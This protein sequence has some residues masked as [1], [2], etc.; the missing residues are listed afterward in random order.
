MV[1]TL[2]LR[3]SV[4]LVALALGAAPLRAQPPATLGP[5]EE[6]PSIP[7]TRVPGTVTPGAEPFP[8]TPNL[9]SGVG[10]TP[11]RGESPLREFGGSISII[12]SAQIAASQQPFLADLFKT[13]PGLDVQQNGGPGR[14]TSIF[15]RGQ[16]SR[17]TKVLVDGIPINDPST[18]QRTFDFGSLN[19]LEIERVEILRGPQSTLY[20]SDAVGG[21]INI[22]TKRGDGPLHGWVSSSAGAYGTTE[23]TTHVAAGNSLF[24]FSMGVSQFDTAG[25]SVANTKYGRF[26]DTEPDGYHQTSLATRFGWT[27]TQNFDIDVVM[28]YLHSKAALD[29]FNQ[30]PFEFVTDDPFTNSRNEQFYGRASARWAILDG[31]FEQRIAFNRTTINRDFNDPNSF[32]P[33]TSTLFHGSTDKVEYQAIA[34]LTENNK[35]TFGIDHTIERFDNPPTQ[36]NQVSQADKAVYVQDQIGLWNRWFTTAGVR[37]DDY[38]LAGVATTWRIASVFRVDEVGSAVHGSYGT[39]FIAPA[40]FEL[41]ADAPP[42]VFGNPHLRPEHDKG[43]EYGFEQSLFDKQL[44][45]DVTYFRIDSRDLIEYVFPTF[46]NVGNARSTGVEF[47][48]TWKLT[49]TTTLTGNYT[50]CRARDLDLQRLLNLRPQQKGAITLNQKLFDGRG[51]WYAQLVAVG[52]RFDYSAPTLFQHMPQHVVVNT[53]FSYDIRPNIQLFAR[54]DNL[55]DANYEEVVGFGT[56]RFSVYGGVKISFGGTK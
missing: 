35:L 23:N 42:F 5:P 43:F 44:K 54:A 34:K 48:T 53:A 17:A 12:D 19:T 39:G 21:V 55:F 3:S 40:L 4:C 28:R 47:T 51:N 9:P 24:Y 11:T 26:F 50:Y 13:Q 25:F 15:M 14:Q 10:L 36:N 20:G 56:P 8:A 52:D 18:P 30:A 29:S 22:I 27:P 6:L 32:F 31:A 46:D 33:P 2:L 41:F 16:A 38:E 37:S 1:R 49:D 45:F 7:P